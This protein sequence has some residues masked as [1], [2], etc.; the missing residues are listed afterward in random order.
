MSR[1]TQDTAVGLPVSLT[2]LSPSLAGFPK[3]FLLPYL[4]HLMQSTTPNRSWVWP[5][6]LSLAATQEIDVSFSSCRYLD[7][8]V[9]GVPFPQ[10]WIGCGMSVLFTDGFPHSDISGSMAMCASPKLFAA[11]Y[12]LHRFLMPRHSPY[13]L[14]SLTFMLRYM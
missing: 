3:T 1:R 5:P 13:A 14:I 6:S 10:L 4:H 7:V 9:H 2:G 8:S 12:V 11:F